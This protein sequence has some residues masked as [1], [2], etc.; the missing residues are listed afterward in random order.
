MNKTTH[1]TGGAA[2]LCAMAVAAPP[3]VASDVLAIGGACLFGSLFPDIDTPGSKL[4]HAIKPIASLIRATCGHRGLFHAPLFYMAILTALWLLGPGWL[5][6]I[7][8][9]FALGVSSHLVLDM[10]N[11]QGIPIL[12]P[13]DGKLSLGK[14]RVGGTGELVIRFVLLGIIAACL[15]AWVG[16]AG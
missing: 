1:L 11:A 6:P 7:I 14:I 8:W 5:H 13:I 9:G 3:T 10:F 2:A 15:A 12:W 4:G 16:K